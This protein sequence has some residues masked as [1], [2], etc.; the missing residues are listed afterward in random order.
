MVSVSSD[1]SAVLQTGQT[2][3]IQVGKRRIAKVRLDK[4]ALK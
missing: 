1:T 2:Y 4:S 3:I